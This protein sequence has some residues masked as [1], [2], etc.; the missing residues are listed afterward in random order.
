[1]YELSPQQ[2]LLLNYSSD[3]FLQHFTSVYWG[4]V[5][6]WY[7]QENCYKLHRPHSKLAHLFCLSS[8]S[9]APPLTLPWSPS[10]VQHCVAKQEE[11]ISTTGKP[12]WRSNLELSLQDGCLFYHLRLPCNCSK[13]QFRRDT[14][15]KAAAVGRLQRR[16]EFGPFLDLNV[17]CGTLFSSGSSFFCTFLFVAWLYTRDTSWGRGH[18]AAKR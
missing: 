8:S 1:M 12:H 5:T 7:N 17:K 4:D 18:V 15:S 3:C 16:S 13:L 10:T 6:R 11:G 2:W 14:Q 9:L